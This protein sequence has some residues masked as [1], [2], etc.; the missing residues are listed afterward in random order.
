ML[1]IWGNDEEIKQL[2]T[3]NK[4][5]SAMTEDEKSEG[6]FDSY[7][8]KEIA[9]TV[10]QPVSEVEDLIQKFKYMQNFHEYLL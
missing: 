3:Q 1:M 10:Q 5:C 9:E 4:I 6:K 8:K 2:E 7:S